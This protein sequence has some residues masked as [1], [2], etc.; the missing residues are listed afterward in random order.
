[1]KK[2]FIF[3]YLILFVS[4]PVYGKIITVDLAGGGDY[5]TIHAAVEAAV[6]GDSILVMSGQYDFTVAL[7]MITV[8]KKLYIIG[9]GYDK[10]V[11]GGTKIY[12]VAGSGL[13]TFDNNAKGSVI[14]GFRMQ[15]GATAISVTANSTTIT[16]EENFIYA[17]TTVNFSSSQRDTVRSNILISADGINININSTTGDF[18]SN[19]L[20]VGGGG[21]WTNRRG[22]YCVSATGLIIANNIIMKAGD[23]SSGYGAIYINSCNPDVYS[24]IF[25]DNYYSIGLSSASPYVT[26]NLFYNNTS[27][28]WG[29]GQNAVEAD[30]KFVNFTPGSTYNSESPD[31]DEYDFHLGS[32]SPAVNTGRVGLSYNDVDGTQND[33]GI[34]GGPW[35]FLNDLGIPTIPEVISI[36][37]TPATVSPSGTITVSATGR[38]GSGVG[39]K[40]ASAPN[41]VPEATKSRT[42]R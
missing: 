36:S 1:M 37:V 20:I 8:S 3:C 2:W 31:N 25:I 33:M 4:V 32:G 39:S 27:N 34:Y 15:T 22:I 10:V 16:V 9:S 14:K 30:P 38:I 12:D 5:E 21:N 18:I 6:S 35:P 29:V 7:G 23:Q 17:A 24:N 41:P 11:D 42:D 13:F 28:G 26:N 40:S 19:N